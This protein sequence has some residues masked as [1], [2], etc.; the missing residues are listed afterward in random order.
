MESE[1]NFTTWKRSAE[2]MSQLDA[3]FTY[4]E[5]NILEISGDIL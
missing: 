2:K 5:K 4:I 1:K 3:K